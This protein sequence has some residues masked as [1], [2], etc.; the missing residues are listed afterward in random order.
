MN[1]SL[2]VGSGAPLAPTHHPHPHPTPPGLATHNVAQRREQL[3]EVL[4]RPTSA[5]LRRKMR[6]RHAL[7][8]RV[9]EKP[10]ATSYTVHLGT[11]HHWYTPSCRHVSHSAAAGAY[12]SQPGS[13]GQ[14]RLCPGAQTAWG[15]L[16]EQTDRP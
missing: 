2:L 3:Y 9:A 13:Q 10:V 8:M 1:G 14:T 7:R 15:C 6:M 11:P 4:D 12:E 16:P 5:R